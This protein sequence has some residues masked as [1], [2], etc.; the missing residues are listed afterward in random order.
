MCCCKIVWWGRNVNA[1]FLYRFIS[2]FKR[3]FSNRT[4]VGHAGFHNSKHHIWMS[5]KNQAWSSWGPS[6]CSRG[7]PNVDMFL[8]T[9]SF[10]FIFFS[11][12]ANRAPR[13]Q[14]PE[15]ERGREKGFG[16]SSIFKTLPLYASISIA[17]RHM[18]TWPEF[19]VGVAVSLSFS[20]FICL[21]FC[22]RLQPDGCTGA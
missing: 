10:I 17:L 22:C 11:T 8:C 6:G 5:F 20:A 19:C 12:A 3:D 13:F 16:C 14:P 7:Q 15:R 21:C 2:S 9:R 4:T 18:R 1:L